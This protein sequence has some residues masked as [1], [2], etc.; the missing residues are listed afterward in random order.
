MELRNR[1]LKIA[2]CDDEKAI[3]FQLQRCTKGT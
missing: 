1:T 3:C 2:I